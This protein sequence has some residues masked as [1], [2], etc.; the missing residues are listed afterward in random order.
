MS[1]ICADGAFKVVSGEHT[2]YG[3]DNKDGSEVQPISRAGA[4]KDA[5]NIRA[6][7]HSV[8]QAIEAKNHKHMDQV[9]AEADVS[10]ES[11]RSASQHCK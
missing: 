10:H 5:A 4:V 3:T 11:E 6:I 8:R 7:K 1:S 9:D 2:N